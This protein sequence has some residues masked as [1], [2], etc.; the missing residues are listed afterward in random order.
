VGAGS[1]ARAAEAGPGPG[2]KILLAEVMA[3]RTIVINLA[4]ESGQAMSQEKIKD[5]ID[6][7]DRERF[8]RAEER[9]SEAA[10]R[11][12]RRR[13]EKTGVDDKH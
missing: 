2:N 11:R 13:R 3:L 5:L 6:H 12:T 8:R 9:V 4:G 7:A 10:K 1:L